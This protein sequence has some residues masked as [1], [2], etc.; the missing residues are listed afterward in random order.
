MTGQLE[1][2]IRK[3]DYDEFEVPTGAWPNA[4]D[5]I[6]F[7]DD[8]QDAIDTAEF[9]HGPQVKCFIRRGTYLPE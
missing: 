4:S 2:R 5:S 6:Y 1:C 3:N 8:K 9:V 7:A